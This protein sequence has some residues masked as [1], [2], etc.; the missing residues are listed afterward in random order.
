[1]LTSEPCRQVWI[2]L[3]AFL[4]LLTLQSGQPAEVAGESPEKGL[5]ALEVTRP[6]DSQS[7]AETLGTF[8]CVF[9]FSRKIA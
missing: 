4:H 2:S 9:V 3:T 1:M 5:P 8:F 7:H 6:T